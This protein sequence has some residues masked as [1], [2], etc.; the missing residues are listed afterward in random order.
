MGI[1][2]DGRLKDRQIGGVDVVLI[3]G[4]CIKQRPA[5]FVRRSGQSSGVNA[6]KDCQATVH[7]FR[8][9]EKRHENT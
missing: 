1:M 9:L 6:T 7:L 4:H 3:Q 8:A 5:G 2:V